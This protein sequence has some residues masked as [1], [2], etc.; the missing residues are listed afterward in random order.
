MNQERPPQNKSFEDLK[1][2]IKEKTDRVYE[3][4][5]LEKISRIRKFANELREQFPNE[6]SEYLLYHLVVGST[7]N[8]PESELKREDFPG[9][10]VEKFIESLS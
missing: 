4:L 10:L 2:R 3:E 5:D 6:Y 7:P 8:K 9:G 1:S